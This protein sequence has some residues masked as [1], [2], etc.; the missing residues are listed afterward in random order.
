PRSSAASRSN[1]ST[2]GPRMNSAESITARTRSSSSGISGA[3]CALT[4]TSG[5]GATARESRGPPTGGYVYNEGDEGG[6][7]DVI[8]VAPDG[9]V[10]RPDRVADPREPEAEDRA[11][12]RRQRDELGKR[13]PREA[14]GNRHEG[15]DARSHEAHGHG[16]PAEAVEPALCAV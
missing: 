7:H 12:D 1:A 16:D 9:A 3:Y 14:R 11:A 13:H 5:I 2:L 10:V 8:E 6:D 4:S 15:P